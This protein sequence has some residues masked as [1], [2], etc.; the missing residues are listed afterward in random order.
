MMA[1]SAFPAGVGARWPAG[2]GSTRRIS[3]T[4]SSCLLR[5]SAERFQRLES[6]GMQA[7]GLAHD[8]NNLLEVV[9][10]N[11]RLALTDPGVPEATHER[12]RQ[13]SLAVKKGRDL[14]RRLIK[15]SHTGELRKDLVQVNQVVETAVELVRPMIGSNVRLTVKL[16]PDLPSIEAFDPSPEVEA[17]L[18][19]RLTQAGEARAGA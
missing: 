3:P 7:A 13:M 19:E 16:H 12:L 1:S 11:V 4:S 5:R 15:F 8:F 14:V 6:A 18:R 10:G 9:S 2:C 17:S